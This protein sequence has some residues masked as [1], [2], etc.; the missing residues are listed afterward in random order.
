MKKFICVLLCLCA[1]ATP[2]SAEFTDR[3][4]IIAALTLCSVC[5]AVGAALWKNL[6][7][8]MFDEIPTEEPGTPPLA[9]ELA[10]IVDNSVRM[11]ADNW[12]VALLV[13]TVDRANAVFGA[14]PHHLARARGI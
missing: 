6:K 8:K 3:T 5:A 13:A 7:E 1:I 10:Q 14:M 2:S 12:R 11:L 9:Q 4:K